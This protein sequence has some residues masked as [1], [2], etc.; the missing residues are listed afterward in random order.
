MSADTNKRPKGGRPSSYSP[1]RAWAV[2]AEIEE[3]GATL[4]GAAKIAGVSRQLVSRWRKTQPDFAEMIDEAGR[5]YMW[6]RMGSIDTRTRKG[7][8]QWRKFEYFCRRRFPGL[9]LF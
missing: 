3:T 8:S 5:G 6:R 1:E 7:R 9:S 2:V 4:S